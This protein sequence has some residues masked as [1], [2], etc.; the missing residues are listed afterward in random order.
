MIT[1]NVLTAFIALANTA[2]HSHLIPSCTTINPHYSNLKVI[3][4]NLRHTK[5]QSTNYDSNFYPHN[6]LS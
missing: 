2:R 6:L 3:H 1:N 5:I 4:V